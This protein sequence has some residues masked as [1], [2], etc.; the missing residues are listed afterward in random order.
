MKH[1]DIYD[2]SNLDKRHREA[3]AKDLYKFSKEIITLLKF[4]VGKL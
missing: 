4:V 1:I 2:T 3:I